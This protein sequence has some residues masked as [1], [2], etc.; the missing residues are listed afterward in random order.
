MASFPTAAD[1][2][3]T[4][5][6]HQPTTWVAKY[7]ETHRLRRIVDFPQGV[8]APSRVRI[9][10]RRDNYMLQWWEPAAKASYSERV[11]GDLI[12]AIARAREIDAR[13]DHFRT[14]GHGQRKLKH[15]ELIDGYLADLR[16]RADAAQLSVNTVDRY[17]SA[18]AHYRAFCA[19]SAISKRF[20]FVAGVNRDF[21]LAFAAYLGEVQVSPNGRADGRRQPLGSRQFVL[22]TTRSMFAWAA[23]PSRGILLPSAFRNPFSSRESAPQ[24]S[25]PDPFGEP[26]VTI[27]MAVEF[28]TACDAFQLKLFAPLMVYGLR[29]TEPVFVFREHVGPDWFTVV[30]LPE[31]NYL[32]KGR[33]DK[34]FPVVRQV[35]DLWKPSLAP[36]GEG[37][38]L[39]RRDAGV[40]NKRT[41]LFGA[42][43]ASLAA[44]FKRRCAAG[45]PTACRRQEIRDAILKEA[46]GLSYD[47]IEA[48]F[49]K[50]ARQ[51]GWPRA[52]TLKDLRHLFSTC[53]ENS[54][55]AEFYRRYLMGHSCGKTPIAT[56]THLNQLQSQFHKALDQDLAPLVDA[57]DRRA[58][59]LRLALS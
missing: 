23:D 4:A 10:S 44:E 3:P 6:D 43:L 46:G 38:L 19:Q 50:L 45:Q 30:C 51:L 49:K 21:Q 42:S 22:D 33:R 56:Y 12:D 35:A 27:A 20:P 15:G 5:A 8:K 40:S 11:R 59:E 25:Q 48:E 39:A 28:L 9:Y 53:L 14:S 32:T 36:A 16:C 7:V 29:A 37:L 24:R 18:L 47:T 55:V 17:A 13:L 1:F 41:P 57:I 2:D 52:A 31:L 54:G 34:R 58:H 26:D